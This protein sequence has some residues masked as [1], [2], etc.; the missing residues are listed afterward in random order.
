MCCLGVFIMVEVILSGFNIDMEGLEEKLWDYKGETITASLIKKII[1]S[2]TPETISAAAARISRYPEPV[3]EL[4]EKARNEVEKARKSNETI[5]FG[6]GHASVAEHA[7]FNFDIMGL[8]R[9]AIEYLEKHR[10][11]AVTEKSQR[12]ITLDGDFVMPEE[13]RGTHFEEEYKLLVK[14]RNQLYDYIRTRLEEKIFKEHYEK[15]GK[16]REDLKKKELNTLE[17]RAKEDARYAVGLETKGQLELSVNARELTHIIRNLKS[18]PIKELQELAEKMEEQAQKRAPSLINEKYT[19][20]TSGSILRNDNKTLEEIIDN[21]KRFKPEELK[22]YKSQSQSKNIIYIN[23]DG[24]SNTAKVTL[25]NE[26]NN[27]NKSE[28]TNKIIAGILFKTKKIPYEEGLYWVRNDWSEEE[29]EKVIDSII[30]ET[31][32]WGPVLREF[33]LP[34]MTFEITMSSSAYA[35]MKR[36]RMSTQIVQD[37]DPDIGFT[38]PL[39]IKE[40]GD[41]EIIKEYNKIMD[42]SR[43]LYYKIK[44]ELGE[45][46]AV[47]ALTNAH[48]RRILLKMNI[49]E[50]F[51]FSLLRLDNHAQWDIRNIAEGMKNLIE[52]QDPIIGK[53]LMGKDEF[54]EFK[55]KIKA[56]R[57]NEEYHKEYNN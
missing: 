1:G 57:N 53:Y 56:E 44:A 22:K 50:L 27:I 30:R 6:L 38:I 37:Y 47:Y 39:Q 31:D 11:I 54:K 43:I 46:S 23:N 18:T 49:R 45:Y 8:S 21:I 14:E 26:N 25:I 13:I 34:D 20:P 4:R 16:K 55:D 17:G 15:T 29:K 24:E 35:Q 10:L 40:L 19:K 2:L 52:E 3:N 33:E 51:A 12:Y 7:Y 9:A 42:K 32:A 36:H 41:E 28:L 48:K 5:I